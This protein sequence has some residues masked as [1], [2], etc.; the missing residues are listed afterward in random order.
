MSRIAKCL[1]GAAIGLQCLFSAELA[2]ADGNCNPRLKAQ[3]IFG[4]EARGSGDSSRCEGFYVSPVDGDPLQVIGVSVGLPLVPPR[5]T[6]ELVL[7][8]AADA[9]DRKGFRLHAESKGLRD[10]YR[11]DT[12]VGTSGRFRWPLSDVVL[13]RPFLMERI[14]VY[15][16]GGS[17]DEM[18]YLPVRLRIDGS[19]LA[20]DTYV[21]LRSGIDLER[22]RWRWRPDNQ[23]GRFG[24]WRTVASRMPSGD[25]RQITLPSDI[26]RQSVVEVAG[27]QTGTSRP[28]GVTIRIAR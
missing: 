16:Y 25:A 17:T 13:K 23:T 18:L 9:A 22:V 28:H 10:Y 15:A 4:Y 24:E 5:D 11:L 27:Y 3:P 19:A 1:L 20:G 12:T 6:T 14:G 7:E 21:S 26:D 8:V 2:L